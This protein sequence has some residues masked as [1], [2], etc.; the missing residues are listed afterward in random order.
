MI[1][2]I[3]A[4]PP[5]TCSV[6]QG[7]AGHKSEN[8]LRGPHACHWHAAWVWAPCLWSVTA[9]QQFS[10]GGH[11][12]NTHLLFQKDVRYISKWN[13]THRMCVKHKG[14]HLHA[15]GTTRLLRDRTSE[16]WDTEI[17]TEHKQRWEPFIP[18]NLSAALIS[19]AAKFR[20]EIACRSRRFSGGFPPVSPTFDQLLRNGTQLD[21]AISV[22]TFSFS[23]LANTSGSCRVSTRSSTLRSICPAEYK[24][25]ADQS[26]RVRSACVRRVLCIVAIT[27]NDTSGRCRSASHSYFLHMQAICPPVATFS[28]SGSCPGPWNGRGVHASTAPAHLRLAAVASSPFP[29]ASYSRTPPFHP[30]PS[31]SP[32]R[33]D[34]RGPPCP[35]LFDRWSHRLVISVR[36]SYL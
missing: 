9:L 23:F 4:H 15:S 28:N 16:P 25:V 22:A 29:P 12:R 21:R 6:H 24:D 14:C 2:I 8:V 20:L 10:V 36:L 31:V 7:D 1:R 30:C 5:K 17:G 3:S 32:W 13:W 11:H 18:T 35:G 19:E 27:S 34:V 33:A 26:L